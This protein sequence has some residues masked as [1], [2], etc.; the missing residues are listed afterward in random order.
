MQYIN[1][2]NNKPSNLF[3]ESSSIGVEISEVKI[4]RDD[5]LVMI[6]KRSKIQMK[7]SHLAW[8]FE[9]I[10][11]NSSYPNLNYLHSN[12]KKNIEYTK[13]ILAFYLGPTTFTF[14]K[15]LSQE[16]LGREKGP[17]K[18]DA[19]TVMDNTNSLLL[20][21]I[22]RGLLAQSDWIWKQLWDGRPILIMSALLGNRPGA[23]VMQ[24]K[25]PA[26]LYT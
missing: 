10:T 18:C 20:H 2:N 13:R 16:R 11:L 25:N 23:Q 7:T 22:G 3:T 19:L 14:Q 4:E 17:P 21:R 6:D 9:Q 15:H 8:K 24:R 1:W 5:M 12:Y 26:A